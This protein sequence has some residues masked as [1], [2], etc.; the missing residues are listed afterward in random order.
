[1]TPIQEE[2]DDEDITMLD[3]L[4]IWSSTSYKSS[5]TWSSRPVQTQLTTMNGKADISFI[6]YRNKVF[7]DA[8]ERRQ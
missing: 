6:R 5:P 1:M 4:E 7:L 3:T 2:E 8:L